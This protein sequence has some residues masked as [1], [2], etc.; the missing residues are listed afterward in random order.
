M[1]KKHN[2][3]L[4]NTLKYKKRQHKT[5]KHIFNIHTGKTTFSKIHYE[6]LQTSKNTTKQPKKPTYLRNTNKNIPKDTKPFET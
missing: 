5:R 3:T 4:K 6:T 1:K 2:K